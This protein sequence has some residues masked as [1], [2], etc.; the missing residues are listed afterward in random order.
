MVEKKACSLCGEALEDEPAIHDVVKCEK[1][2]LVKGRQ[3]IKILKASIDFWKDAWFDLREI[4][5]R[6][7]WRHNK[8]VC[9]HEVQSVPDTKP[10][11]WRH[12]N[13]T[14]VQQGKSVY[15]KDGIDWKLVAVGTSE[16]AAKAVIRLMSETTCSN[17]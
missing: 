12:E 10:N 5:G 7:S 16:D 14:V 17:K 4:I 1:T 13:E 8:Y 9:P 6:L 2:E 11:H 15:I 3:S